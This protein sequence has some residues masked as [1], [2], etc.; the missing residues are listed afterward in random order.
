MIFLFFPLPWSAREC[1]IG[2]VWLCFPA[3]RDADYFHNLLSQKTLR[4]FQPAQ[5]GF[6]FSNRTQSNILV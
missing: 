3:V 6:V 2:F 4:K 1:E 5:I